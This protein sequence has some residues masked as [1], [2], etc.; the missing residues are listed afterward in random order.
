M[1]FYINTNT[2]A[3]NAPFI[4]VSRFNEGQHAVFCPCCK[5]EIRYVAHYGNVNS[6]F[7]HYP[8]KNN[9]PE[10]MFR[11]DRLDYE[12]LAEGQN[13]K[14]YGRLMRTHFLSN[15]ELLIDTY[16]LLATLIGR[17]AI[18][19][20]CGIVENP[21]LRT[22]DRV[23]L[24]GKIIDAFDAR[25]G[26]DRPSV[27]NLRHFSFSMM[28]KFQWVHQTKNLNLE[29]HDYKWFTP[30]DGPSTITR[31]AIPTVGNIRK[32]GREFGYIV[33]E[34]GNFQNRF[35]SQAINA[36]HI[37]VSTRN[38]NKYAEIQRRI[39]KEL[40]GNQE[41]Y[42]KIMTSLEKRIDELIGGMPDY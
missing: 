34:F 10:C 3:N 5:E 16:C 38:L 7:A 4:H 33:D 20:D 30:E 40:G 28:T 26:W 31:R 6:H 11:A 22:Q 21:P 1:K 14:F 32:V 13:P 24:L 18:I 37:N 2:P 36:K 8:I 15:K 25:W 9:S 23:N 35:I 27:R 19:N 39:F 42:E 12:G 41:G 29:V 17:K